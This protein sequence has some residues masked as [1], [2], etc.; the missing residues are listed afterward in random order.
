MTPA[1][2]MTTRMSTARKFLAVGYRAYR[3]AAKR[4]L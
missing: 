2:Q 1:P 4:H 3:W